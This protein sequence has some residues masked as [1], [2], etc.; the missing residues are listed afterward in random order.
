[1]TCELRGLADPSISATLTFATTNYLPATGKFGIGSE[2]SVA[3]F[4]Y[5]EL[6]EA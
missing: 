5:F 1:M 2:R 4:S 6:S 3:H